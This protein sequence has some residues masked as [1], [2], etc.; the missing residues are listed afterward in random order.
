MRFTAENLAGRPPEKGR[1]LFAR[2]RLLCMREAL[3]AVYMKQ[4]M[5][6]A[7]IGLVVLAA[8]LAFFE[9]LVFNAAVALIVVLAVYE[10]LQAAG[11]AKNRALLAVSCLY[12]GSVPFI[13]YFLAAKVFPLVAFCY[14]AVLF[15]FLLARHSEITAL[16]IGFTFFI[17]TILPFALTVSIYMRDRDGSPVACFLIL[18]GLAGAWVSDSGAYFAGRAFGRRPLAPQVSPKKTVE[19]S[20]GGAVCCMLG[21]LLI[22]AVYPWVSEKFFGVPVQVNL[23][24]V[25]LISPVISVAGM[26]G[27]LT[28]SVI[29]RQNGVKDYGNIMPGHGGIMDRFDSVLFTVPAVFMFAQWLTLI[30]V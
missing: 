3:G 30:R 2:Q 15:L 1:Q 16:Q 7:G 5:I 19:G 24:L 6:S 11:C 12:S 28:A 4:R 18:L 9:T 27:D 17:A 26:L 29:K 21:F 20:I 13:P 14:I 22:A 25:L 23:P 10:L 8:V